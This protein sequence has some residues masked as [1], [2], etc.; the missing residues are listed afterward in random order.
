MV[1][2]GV[3]H[4]VLHAPQALLEQREKLYTISSHL[5]LILCL[6]SRAR[7]TVCVHTFFDELRDCT[8]IMLPQELD[9]LGYSFS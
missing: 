5:V 1:I 9:P 3:L 6:A 2:H 8:S 4:V 7:I